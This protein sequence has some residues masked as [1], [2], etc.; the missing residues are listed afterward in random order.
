MKHLIIA[1]GLATSILSCTQTGTNTEASTEIETTDSIAQPVVAEQTVG[2]SIGDEATDFSLP[3]I[4]DNMVSLNNYPDAKGFIV[5]FTCNHCPYAV[6]YEQRIVDLHAKYA[7]IGY[8]VIAISP[9]DTAVVPEDGFEGM[10][11]RAAEKGFSFAYCLDVAQTIYPQYGATKTPHVY[12]LQKQDDKNI[13]QYIG[14]IDNNYEDPTDVTET[15]VE[16]AVN[17]LLNGEEIKTKTTKAIGCS[18]KDNRT[19]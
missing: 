19:K 9:N 1:F 17:A 13:V 14:A 15:Y 18:I 6:A 16:D 10:K 2:Y 12:I 11:K 7:A 8:P 4:D 3:G 5:I